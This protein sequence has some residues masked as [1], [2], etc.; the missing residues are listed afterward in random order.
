MAKLDDLAAEVKDPDLRR[1][2]Q[3]AIA[4]TKRKQRLGL[5]F[6]EHFPETTALIGFPVQVGGVVRLRGNGT[7]L[8]RVTAADG[9]GR[10]TVEPV[11]GGDSQDVAASDVMVVKRFGDPIYPSLTSVGTVANG[12]PHRPHHAV[13]SGENY[14]VLQLLVYLYPHKI[15]CIYIDPPYNS[16]AK[17]WKYDNRYVDQNDLWRHSKWLSFMK[18]RLLLAKQLLNPLDSVL[19]VTID[20]KEYLRLGLLLEQV[21]D[22]CNIQMVST[23]INPAGV[24]RAGAFGRSDEYIFFVQMGAASPQR[25]RLPREW[26]SA[27]GQTHTG[28]IRWDLLRRSGPG[29]A[30][31]DR[32]NCFYPIYVDPSGPI[33]TKVGE[34]IPPGEHA[35]ES[36]HGRVAVL[37]IRQNGGEGRWQRKSATVRHRLAQGRVR[38]TGSEA[39]GFVISIL[40]DGEFAKVS[41]GEFTVTGCR[42]DGSLI[43]D[44]IDDS[45]VLAIPGSQWRINSHDSTQY[46]TRLLSDLLPSAKFPFPKSLYA[47]EDTLRFFVKDK[48]NAVVLDF[49]AGSGTTTHAVVRLNRQDGGQRRSISV[50]NNEVSADEADELRGRGLKPGDADWEAFG[51]FE[52]VT[53]PRV[54]AAVSGR[55]PD[56]GPVKGEYKFTDP[57]PMADGFAENVEFFRIDYLDPDDVDLGTQ[58]DAIAP[59][60]W[61][62][63]GGVG[64][65]VAGVSQ[66]SFSIPDGSTYGVLFRESGFR[67]FRD[68]LTRRPDVSHVWIVTDSEE[69]YAEMC[70]G[71]PRSLKVSMLY[72]DYLRNFLINTRHVP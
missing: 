49:F 2:L 27:R 50:T 40:K 54:A 47:V 25:V 41:R 33:V 55:T 37:P 42:P 16:G 39:T 34:P 13:I 22:G 68:E 61:L 21:F 48:P 56:G 8:Y 71:L 6:E 69:A 29:S 32:P 70:S 5:V 65:W 14:H 38:V 3:D 9:G 63:A 43:V 46:G 51:I 64:R 7:A 28:T 10:A 62:A 4:E 26:V 20:E 60:L 36:M 24:S 23:L 45:T 58:F 52:H 57:S 44:D 18:R 53:R 15:D 31:E 59:S 66:G 12:A 11:G 35:A 30:R 1:R 17:D 67:K 72:R 19:I